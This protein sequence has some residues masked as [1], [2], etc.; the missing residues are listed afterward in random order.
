MDTTVVKA[1]I[2]YP[3]DA[4]LLN[5]CAKAISGAVK[6][7]GEL[8]SEAVK[9]FRSKSRTMKEKTLEITKVLR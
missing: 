4:G 1:N 5:D 9:H 6:R 2:H 3:T 8:C 7:I